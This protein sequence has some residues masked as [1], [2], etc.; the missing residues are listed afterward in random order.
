MCS[1]KACSLVINVIRWLYY[2]TEH[3]FSSCYIPQCNV[4]SVIKY[5][6]VSSQ[7]L[8]VW[9]YWIIFFLSYKILGLNLNRISCMKHC[10]TFLNIFS[11][12][13]FFTEKQ[14]K[15][16]GFFFPFKCTCMNMQPNILRN[17]YSYLFT[18]CR[19]FSFIEVGTV[20]LKVW[21]F[22]VV[23]IDFQW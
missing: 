21:W 22:D 6:C 18:F 20:D 10:N 11:V 17:D 23:H 15:H 9:K 14:F 5:L 12:H 13:C 16:C 4:Y 3:P 19:S 7:N 8:H 1:L 2:Y